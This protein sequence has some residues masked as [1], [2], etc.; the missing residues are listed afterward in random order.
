MISWLKRTGIHFFGL[1]TFLDVIEIPKPQKPCWPYRHFNAIII[2]SLLRGE[3]LTAEC[4]R[5]GGGGNDEMLLT[6][7]TLSY[8]EHSEYLITKRKEK[9]KINIHQQK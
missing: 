8:T 9:H 4:N 3:T 7:C 6:L 1:N 5:R 2:N